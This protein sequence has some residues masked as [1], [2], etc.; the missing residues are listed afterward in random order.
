MVSNLVISSKNAAK[1]SHRIGLNLTLGNGWA[2]YT[3][4]LSINILSV[5]LIAS[6]MELNFGQKEKYLMY[7]SNTAVFK[8]NFKTCFALF[9]NGKK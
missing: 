7:T 1:S 2:G 3:L 8:N 4:V 9:L 5:N 6:H